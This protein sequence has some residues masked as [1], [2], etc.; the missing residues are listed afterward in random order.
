MSTP[1]KAEAATP[2]KM[3]P[4]P[5]RIHFIEQALTVPFRAETIERMCGVAPTG[6]VKALCTRFGIEAIR[7]AVDSIEVSNPELLMI[8]PAKTSHG[9]LCQ[10][11]HRHC[12]NRSV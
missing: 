12:T 5:P 6:M 11:Y 8:R 4:N 2:S 7:K 1:S 10:E 3:A 9:K